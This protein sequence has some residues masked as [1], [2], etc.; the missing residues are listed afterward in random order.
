MARKKISPALALSL[1]ALGFLAALSGL[2]V[3]AAFQIGGVSRITLH[4][5]IA[6]GLAVVFTGLLAGGLMWLAFFSATH[7]YDDR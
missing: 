5:W 6:L 3:V 1:A 7:G 2:G 4:G